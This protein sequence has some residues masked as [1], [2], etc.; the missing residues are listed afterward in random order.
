MNLYKIRGGTNKDLLN[1]HYNIGVGISLGNRW[2]TPENIVSLIEW[3]MIHTKE[4]VI[5]YVADFIHAI[6]IEV[7]NGKSPEKA[8]EKA[9]G[10][11]A[12]ILEQIK[13][14][15]DGKF[16]TDEKSKIFYATWSDLLIPSFRSK[17]E[18]L[19]ECYRRVARSFSSYAH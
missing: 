6:N 16:G 11:G 17:V 1:R 12:D 15:V 7:R 13:N 14:L 5:V 9:L 18:F 2:F 3:S 19:Y 8:E 10:M 4:Y